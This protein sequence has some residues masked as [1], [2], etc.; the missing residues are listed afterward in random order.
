MKEHKLRISEIAILSTKWKDCKSHK[1]LSTKSFTYTKKI[2]V[3]EIAPVNL[4]KIYLL[5]DAKKTCKSN[6]HDLNRDWINEIYISSISFKN[7]SLTMCANLSKTII[8]Y[9]IIHKRML[10]RTHLSS[11]LPH[12]LPPYLSEPKSKKL[13]DRNFNYLIGT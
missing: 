5:K 1:N 4:S 3:H 6:N 8:Y 2:Y 13:S 7:Y 11:A 9:P 10:D 12:L